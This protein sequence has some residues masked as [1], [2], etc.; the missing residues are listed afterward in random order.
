MAENN[1]RSTLLVNVI[2]FHLHLLK[3]RLMIVSHKAKKKQQ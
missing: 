3:F 1:E 2:V